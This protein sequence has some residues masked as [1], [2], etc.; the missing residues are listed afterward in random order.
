[1]ANQA[2]QEAGDTHGRQPEDACCCYSGP[3]LTVV[4]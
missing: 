3:E 2:V 1:M 4:D